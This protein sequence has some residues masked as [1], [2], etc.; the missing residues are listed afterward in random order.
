MW[1]HRRHDRSF[2]PGRLS[3]CHDISEHHPPDQPVRMWKHESPAAVSTSRHFRASSPRSAR[4][5][6]AA[7]LHQPAAARCPSN[8][9]PSPFGCQ[10]PANTSS[11][12]SSSGGA[13]CANGQVPASQ[14]GIASSTCINPTS[15][16]TTSGGPPPLQTKSCP[17]YSQQFP[18]A[19]SCPVPLPSSS[20]CDI[21]VRLSLDAQPE[22]QSQACGT[23]QTSSSGTP[24]PGSARDHVQQRQD[25]LPARPVQ[26]WHS[27]VPGSVC[28]V[29]LRHG[30]E[31][32]RLRAVSWW[33]GH[34]R[35]SR[36]ERGGLPA[37]DQLSG[38][39]RDRL[40]ADLMPDLSRRNG[41]VPQGLEQLPQA[42]ACVNAG[43]IGVC[44]LWRRV[45]I[46]IAGYG[47]ARGRWAVCLR[48][49]FSSGC[50]NR[51]ADVVR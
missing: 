40:S 20:G 24:C 3:Q 25:S 48:Q 46:A 8:I 17:G 23:N 21:G 42:A 11:S 29:Q 15:S 41:A 45:I 49:L 35:W 34:L 44:E 16:G 2:E 36:P 39:R 27:R 12:S 10:P 9:T 38:R 26:R 37:G 4:R 6:V 51:D 1:E 32:R 13:S 43:A 47:S 18:V 28:L 50:H 33:D 22:T 14:L 5:D 19:Q 30:C 7:H 31:R